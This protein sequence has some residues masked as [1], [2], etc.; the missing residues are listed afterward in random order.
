MNILAVKNDGGVITVN[1]T[2]LWII[3]FIVDVTFKTINKLYDGT[4][5]ANRLNE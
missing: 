2:T 4:M 5:M 3:M 1:A